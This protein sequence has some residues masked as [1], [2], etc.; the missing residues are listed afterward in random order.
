MDRKIISLLG[1][2]REGLTFQKIMK[3]LHLSSRERQRLR[4]Q[5]RK[6][7]GQG[8]V[9]RIKSRYFI[10]LKSSLA[11]GR[12]LTSLR[13]FGFVEQEDGQ[14][15]D[16][17]IPARHSGGALQGDIVE[18]LYREKG[19]KA[20]PEGRVIRILKQGKK[21]IIGLYREQN[22][23]PFF[24]PFDS[25]SSE[26]IPLNSNGRISPLPGMIVEV[27]RETMTLESILGMPDDPGVD[28]KVVIQRFNLAHA[29][30]EEAIAEARKISPGIHPEDRKKR[31]DYRNWL[32]MT[33]DGE[34][35][36]DFDD[37]V[38]VRKLE[39]GH[40]LLG[41]HIADVSHYV[42]S[43]SLLDKEAFERGTS[44][45]F[46]EVTLPMLPE[47]LSNDICSL[48]PKEERLTFS[49]LLEIDGEGRVVKAEF[50]PSLIQ[51]AERMTYDSVYKIF[52][53]DEAEKRKFSTLVPDL[54]LMRH[55]A[56]LLR[57]KREME[58]S[59]D[60]DLHEPEL[61]YKEGSLHSI[62]PSMRNEAHQVIEDFMVAANEAVASF[63]SREN[64]PLIY[65]IHPPPAIKDL[66]RL[67]E[68]LTHF[69][70]SLPRSK[71]I[72]SRDLQQALKGFAG[73]SG[74][75]V[76][77]LQV[78]RSLKL[79]VYSDENLG[80]FGL[81]KDEYTHFTSPIRR[82]PDLVVHRILKR[83]ITQERIKPSPF[84]SV[85]LH[86]SEQ[87]RKAEGAEKELLEW[88]IF[89]F[90]KGKLGDELGGTIVDITRAGLV[91]ELED[92]F[93]DG[94]VF[95]N[96]LEG[97]YYFKR[98]DKIL[99]GRRSGRTFELGNTL[100]VILASVDPILRRITLT[101]SPEEEKKAR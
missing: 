100:K 16:I 73:K 64:V 29:F 39:N 62:V 52:E 68:I 99:V 37:A 42:K 92:F 10:P 22:R 26:E 8:I 98:S 31:E 9:R 25:P 23:Q 32:T 90:L 79:A 65:R 58:G 55:V 63:L 56:Q 95:F 101:L 96:D 75:K 67:R 20:K 47:V 30:S 59:L 36:Q 81:A 89:R 14:T 4:N 6:M 57:R 17:F 41:V 80:H 15:E 48:R 93:V 53:K 94:I 82:Y 77:N 27:D 50:R 3:E 24:L 61:V 34:T 97:D 85:A 78:L 40:F 49:V 71:K 66:K 72:K 11:I 70:I 46:P 19:R 84:S 7:E 18:V 69:G 13:G 88:R 74:E 76:V 43:D 60:F 12:F 91:V 28:V 21:R 45:Y 38:S 33:I 1:R 87:E 44:V 54:L 2:R 83:A 86:C 5:L 35:A 51:T